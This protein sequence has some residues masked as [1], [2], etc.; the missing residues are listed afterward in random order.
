MSRVLTYATVC[1]GIECMS[2]AARGL[3]LRPVFFSEIEPF[4]CAVLKARYPTIPN[5]GDMSKIRR[6]ENGNITNG[7][8]TI[9]F[10]DG[11]IDIL[12]AGCPC[13]DYSTAGKRAGGEQG[14][15]TRSS[16][17][18][19]FIRIIGEFRPRY[20]IYE[21]VPGMF[22]T[23][24]G[25]D[26]AHVIMEMEQCGYSLAWR[27]LDAQYVRV[28]GMERAVPQRRRRVWVV[29]RL[30]ADESVPAEILFEPDCV[31]GHTPPRRIAGQGFA[32]SLG[33]RDSVDAGMVGRAPGTC[34]GRD[35]G[36][37]AGTGDG[38]VSCTTKQISLATETQCAGPII[39]TDY[40]EPQCIA[41][42]GDKLKPRADQRKG[43]N[44]FGINEDGA[45][46]TLTGVDRHG[47]AYAADGGEVAATITRQ[48]AEQ[49]G[50]DNR[51]NAV[52]HCAMAQ[53]TRDEVRVVG[54]GNIAGALAAQ[55]GMKQ[56]TYVVSSQ[57]LD[58]YN[59]TLTGECAP[60][61][62]GAASD[63]HH[64]HGVISTNSNGENVAPTISS[65]EYKMGQQQKDTSGGYVITQRKETD[66]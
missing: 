63:I 4:P 61:I 49:S 56:Q 39:S 40:K 43:G 10:P 1:S 38:C 59:Q 23:H 57:G 65:C 28:D 62:S 34:E 20:F 7:R 48:I 25:R 50:Q 32:Y 16:L 8:T 64:T 26:F 51:A 12:A 37:A 66:E 35:G 3:P 15:G 44:G 9:P 18:F 29:G 53:N 55:P 52:I 2:V 42:D 45:G 31:A 13:Q 46:Y 60:T 5:L 30:G 22:T 17:I 27:V 41:L 33:G 47:V 58:G 11:G 19:E 21:N 14:S 36:K 24:E 6:D 54:D